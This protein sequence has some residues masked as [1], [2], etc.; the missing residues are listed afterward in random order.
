MLAAVLIGVLALHMLCTHV[1]SAGPVVSL[2]LQWKEHRGDMAAG[3][4]GR[5]LAW[6][7]IWL[8]LL[9]A[10]FGASAGL[11]LWDAH[12]QA[13]LARLLHKVHMGVWEYLISL[14]LMIWYAVLWSR[15]HRVSTG[16]LVGRS[17]LAGFAGLNLLYHF[18]VFFLI[19]AHFASGGSPV[20]GPVETTTFQRMILHG[21][22][23]ARTTHFALA[24][25]A[26]TGVFMFVY[27]LR[28]RRGGSD[29]MAERQLAIWGGRIGLA[30]SLVQLPVGVWILMQLDGDIQRQMMG[31]N[32]LVTG[33]FATSVVLS[34]FLMHQL[35][36]VSLGDARSP[37][38][39]TSVLL[40]IVVIFLMVA[41][42]RIAVDGLGPTVG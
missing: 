3:E 18:P 17:F 42:A 2:W 19:L 41:V 14:G 40:M 30:A 28:R 26:V 31:A 24:S 13:T 15:T 27:V 20:E 1:A 35:A 11:L 21:P 29:G 32:Y 5:F 33:L 23:L 12:Y 25:F 9:G 8:L 37:R 36:A 22:V 16:R 7:S 4:C 6:W 38:L 34:L 39:V 10:L